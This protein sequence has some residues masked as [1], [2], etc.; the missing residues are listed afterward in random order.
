MKQEV[1][2]VS[3]LMAVYN[4]E[5][6]L[7]EA[8][9][10]ILCQTFTEF[11]FIIID[12]CSIDSTSA[13]IKTYHDKRINVFRNERNIG[14]TKSLNIGL[15]K[16]KGE[17][18][19]RQDADDRSHAT[20][21]QLQLDFLDKNPDVVLLGTQARS[22]DEF[23]KLSYMPEFK[24]IS[25]A[26][27]K[28]QL[29][30]GNPFIHSTVMFNAHIIKSTFGGYNEDFRLSQDL[31]L[32]SRVIQNFK[33]MNLNRV[34]LDFRQNSNS[35]TKFKEVN[36]E[37]FIDN[38]RKNV[39]VGLSNLTA[40]SRENFNEWPYQWIQLNVPHPKMVEINPAQIFRLMND[41]H[42]KSLIY[43]KINASETKSLAS[44]NF[45]NASIRMISHSYR[46]SFLLFIK[47]LSFNLLV[48][49]FLIKTVFRQIR[50]RLRLN[51]CNY[52][53]NI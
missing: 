48:F 21:L 42:A 34:C 3:I 52:S 12:D 33:C 43:S 35:V 49:T 44:V 5:R 2:K 7:K 18:I 24:P 37:L 11:E 38:F 41:L 27:V 16:A 47:A 29:F 51:L 53:A 6:H 39:D 19:A 15:N 17:Y 9:D 23:G 4:G 50:K 40:I 46:V 10:S 1:P 14:L 8:I 45:Y 28:Y 32:W 13:I 36:R 26:G 31:E 20:R 30:F 22:I 25:Y